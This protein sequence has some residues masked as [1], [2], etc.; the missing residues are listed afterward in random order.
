[1]EE[2]PQ[3][4]NTFHLPGG[5]ELDGGRRA[6]KRPERPGWR[7]WLPTGIGGGFTDRG[8]WGKDLKVLREQPVPVWRN[9]IPGGVR[10]GTSAK[11][12]RQECTPEMETSEAGGGWTL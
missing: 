9:S 10:E 8:M 6:G 1:M 4:T 12:L 7:L 5:Q 11:A 3:V 2:S